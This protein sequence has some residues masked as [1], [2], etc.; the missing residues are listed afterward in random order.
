MTKSLILQ[1]GGGRCLVPRLNCVVFFFRWIR[2]GVV[3]KEILHPLYWSSLILNRI[4]DSWIIIW[5]YLSIYLRYLIT[6]CTSRVPVEGTISGCCCCFFNYYYYYYYYYLLL[7]LLL[8]FFWSNSLTYKANSYAP[9]KLCTHTDLV[10][11]VL[12]FELVDQ[13]CLWLNSTCFPWLQECWKEIN[14][15]QF[16]IRHVL[17]ASFLCQEIAFV[18]V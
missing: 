7:L 6:T 12:S 3:Y 11:A 9:T 4:Q 16:D 1:K 10:W 15:E 2:L 14:L 5:T 17:W 18:T 8:F 13:D